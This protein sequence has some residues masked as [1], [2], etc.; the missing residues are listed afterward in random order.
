MRTL[1]DIM[2]IL[3]LSLLLFAVV[4]IA[5][6]T[7]QTTPYIGHY[8]ER[9][10]GSQAYKD[11]D[12]GVIFYVE[13]DGRHLAAIS[14]DGKVLWNRDPFSD[15]HLEPYR[16]NQPKIVWVGQAQKWELEAISTKGSGKF[17]SI[18]YNSSQFG[19][20]D[21]KTGDFTFMGQD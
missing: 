19:V 2:K 20:V 10:H 18:D 17:I 1:F 14:P 7:N 8:L 11:A 9:F 5:S 3:A 4:A 21:I 15:S 12:S 16:T 13:S 6:E